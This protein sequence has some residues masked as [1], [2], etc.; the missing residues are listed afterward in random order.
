MVHL[1]GK[2]VGSRR[3]PLLITP[4]IKGAMDC[5]VM[6]RG[7]CGIAATNEYFFATPS[8]GF[9]NGWQAMRRVATDAGLEKAYLIQ[10]TRMRK[11]MAT[12]TQVT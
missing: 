3:V 7:I 12:V 11:Y 4:D 5:L 9:I 2:G 6:A 8:T 1:P 10:S